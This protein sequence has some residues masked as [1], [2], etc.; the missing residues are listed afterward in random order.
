MV[1]SLKAMEMKGILVSIVTFHLSLAW[2]ILEKPGGQC[3]GN[4]TKHN[5]LFTK[6]DGIVELFYA[7]GSKG[8]SL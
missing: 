2:R 3:T 8:F 4:N 1:E 5:T 6:R 7:D